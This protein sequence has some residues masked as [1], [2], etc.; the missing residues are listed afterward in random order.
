MRLVRLVMLAAVALV[1]VAAGAPAASA[2]AG[3]VLRP[4]DDP[5]YAVPRHLDSVRDGTVL[6]SRRLAADTLTVPA[7]A[8]V[9]QLLYKTRD[10]A[11]RPTATV[12]TLLV[13]TARWTG[14]GPRPLLS[15]QVPEDGL[16][17]F[18]APSYLLRAGAVPVGPTNIGF[19]APQVAAAVQRGWSVIVPDYEGPQSQFLG[20][21][22]T[23]H[24]IL[25]GI[26]AARSFDPAGVDRRA[27]IGLWG[28]S[29]GGFATAVAAQFQPRYAPELKIAGFA[30]GGVI[31]DLNAALRTIGGQPF[32]GWLPFGF[33][34]LDNAY[35]R[36]HVEQYL[37]ATARAYA[38]ADAHGCA[39]TAIAGG[40][41]NATLAS[42]EAWP[43]SL[44]AGR[45]AAFA[46]DSSPIG[47][48]GTPGAPVYMYHGT[49][50]EL[51]PVEAARRLAARYRTDGAAVTL[52]Q[53]EGQSHGGEQSYGVAGAVAFLTARL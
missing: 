28:Y 46:H 21:A 49:A 3:T 4:D 15:Y 6:R 16:A 30:I 27:P 44:T 47:L 19:D 35:P 53:D 33:A 29:G 52:V 41:F 17:T 34:A 24:G 32:S 11:G 8:R 26:R 36:A 10:N 38:A 51:L 18:C 39:G 9:W 23:A 50:D 25:D 5:F 1:A 37:N 43:G 48:G 12:G 45:F 2:S 14:P 31:A 7:P 22:A 40:P 13:P 42:L 20:A